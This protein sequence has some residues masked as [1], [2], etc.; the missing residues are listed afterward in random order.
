MSATDY[1]PGFYEIIAPGCRASAEVVVPLILER[2][3]A[4]SVI[5]V[6]CGQGW[7]GAEFARHGCA[8]TGVDG[9]YVPN[10]QIAQFIDHDLAQPLPLDLG[11]FDLAVCLEV[12]EHL[13]KRRAAS[14][15]AD[16]CGLAP[17]VVFSAAIPGQTGAGHV[18]C[19]W[20][21]WWARLFAAHG[22]HLDGSLRQVIWDDDRIEPWYRQNLLIATTEPCEPPKD[23]EHPIIA[24]WRT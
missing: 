5:D 15:V 12:A 2:Q 8:V 23:L 13:P 24:G 6:G 16:L 21:S 11:S 22:F 19:R 14:F 18:N 3:P 20:P 9:G 4:K 17:V 10:R 7:W 1:S